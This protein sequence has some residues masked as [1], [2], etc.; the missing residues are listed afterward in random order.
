MP[1]A[2]I[3]PAAPLARPAAAQTRGRWWRV[4][5]PLGLA[6]TLA[7]LPA[8]AG[9]PQHTWF[10]LAIFVGVVAALV[11]EPLPGGAVGLI[12]VTLVGVLA[13]W[14]L[15]SPDELAR[16]GFRA[17]SAALAWALSGF[18][19][20][21]VWLIFGAFMFALG[22][23]KTGLGRR[24]ALL[25]V[26]R[27]GGRTLSLC[28]AIVLADL[29]LAP[30]TPSN[31]ARSGGTIFPV[32]RNLP[33]LYGSHPHSPSARR[34]GSCLMWVAIAATCVTSSLFLTGLATNLLAVEIIRKSTGSAPDWT[35]WFVA[36]LPVGAILLALVPP[37]TFWLYPPEI[38]SSSAV[39]DWAAA[40][41]QTM[42]R[43]RPREIALAVLVMLALAGWIF[44]GATISPTLVALAVIAAMLL[45]GI[46][47]WDDVVGHKAAWNT[48]AWF[49]TLVALADGLNRT[50]FIAWF[51]SAAGRHVA[52]VSPQMASIGLTLVFFFSHYFFAS[53]TAHATALLPVILVLGGSVPGLA[54]PEF[55][56]QLGL[57]LGIMGIISPYATGPSPI[58]YGSGYLP[59]R[60]YWRLGAIFG[61][62][63]LVVYLAVGLPWMRYLNAP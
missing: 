43:I 3:S 61:A 24:L 42:G 56:L 1:P 17:E 28:Y 13:P 21:T 45:G 52:G 46:V 49:A 55:A 10:Y 4:A 23:D 11:F 38:R 63:F 48:L 27:M 44:A 12:G 54:I 25:L 47:S 26:Q 19:N 14:V 7:V 50:G 5:V 20:G 34:I 40:E 6:A 62:V 53:T 31:T 15:L 36:F 32:L 22:Y 30:F 2:E 51:S 9:L 37:L 39:R 16:P 59:A 18:A 35:A 29:L 41:L 58:Y 57:T 8:P 60:D 33:P